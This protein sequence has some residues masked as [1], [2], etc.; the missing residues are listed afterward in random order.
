[1]HFAIFGLTVSSSWGNG[2]ATLWRSLIKAMLNRGHQVTFFERDVPYY[3]SER[4]L[5]ALPAGGTLCL[6]PDLASIEPEVRRTLDHADVAISTSFCPDGPTAC[7]WILNSDAR[8]KAFYDLDTPV[9]LD[10]LETGGNVAYLPSEGLEAFDLVLSYTGG[11]ALEQLQSRLGAKRVAPLYGSVDPESHHPVAPV[12]EY[13]ADLS[14]LGTYAADRQERLARLF[15]EPAARLPH[16][17]FLIGGAQYPENF[18]WAANIAFKRHVSPTRH[19]A[20]FCSSRAT[21]NITRAAM[22]RYGFCP[23]GRLFEAAACGVP[24]LSDTWEGLD[25]FFEPGREILPVR[26]A[27][28]VTQALS[29][30]D[31]ELQDIAAAARARTL[32]EHTGECRVLELER[33]C[34][35]VLQA[36]PG[37]ALE[38]V[39]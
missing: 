32:A 38:V 17:D 31:R 11:L 10:A 30:S 16:A 23:S 19:P 26:T 14:Y 21:L 22:A 7:D 13:R 34:A 28:E 36:V 37:A 39:A 35:A 6:Y 20:F 1:M 25:R 15:L 3:S 5:N 12:E 8:I 9:T 4:D 2:H 27:D 29:L 33:L 18:P 24:L